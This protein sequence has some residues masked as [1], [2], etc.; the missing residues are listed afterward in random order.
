MAGATELAIAVPRAGVTVSALLDRPAGA[1]ALLALAHG[2]GA[3]MRHPFLERLSAALAARRIAVLRYQFPYLES[4]R[5]RPDPTA[6]HEAT[7]RAAVATASELASDLPLAA[8]GKSMGGRMSSRAAAG[9]GLDPV[10]GLVFFGFPLHPAGRPGTARADHLTRVSQPMLFLS[11]D[12]DRLAELELL[13]PVCR[14]LGDRTTLR[15]VAGADHGFHVLKR[16]GRTDD[17]VLEELA[18]TAADWIRG[19]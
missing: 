7:V 18:A 11:G 14:R 9:G 10:R 8:G 1:L 15:V 16:S 3:G 2:A 12:R 6:T 5:R 13:R 17:Q 4:G 19:L